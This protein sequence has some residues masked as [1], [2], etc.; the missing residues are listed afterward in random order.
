MT[1]P[2]DDTRDKVIKLENE[3]HHLAASVDAMAVK[4]TE[5]H[6]LIQQAK[7]IKWLILAAAA[8]GGF[9]SAKI[10]AFLPWFSVG[11]R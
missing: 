4:V 10:A 9:I 2:Y 5:M 3:V 6:D 1:G 11:P 7:G 8:V